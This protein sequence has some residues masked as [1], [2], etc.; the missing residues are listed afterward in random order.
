MTKSH[1]IAAGGI[2]FKGEKLLLVRYRGSEKGSYFVCPGGRLEDDENILQ[3]IIREV[4]EE[5]G[6]QVEPKRVIAIED[7]VSDRTKMIK[8]WMLCDFK[9][10]DLQATLEAE[11]EGIVE[12]GWFSKE[13]LLGEVLFPE[14]LVANDWN[15]IQSESWQVICLPS[16][17]ADF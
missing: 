14:I 9:A 16:T 17:H 12:V 10:G 2:V 11:K 4:N 15:K 8:V 1:R 3:A 7:L 5:T 13:Q 6:I